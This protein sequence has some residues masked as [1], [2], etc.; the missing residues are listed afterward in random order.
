MS[1]IGRLP[2][3]IFLLSLLTACGGFSAKK[4]M[5]LETPAD[6]LLELK[7]AKGFGVAYYPEY[8]RLEVFNPWK[9]KQVHARYYLTRK[10]S[11][12]LPAD[13]VAIQ[14]PLKTIAIASC[15]HIE[16]LRLLGVLNQVKAVCNASTIYN[17]YLREQIKSHAVA[18]IGDAF[19]INAE[20]VLALQVQAL[21]V[22]GHNQ[23]DERIHF[24]EGTGLPVL[25]NNEWMESDL[26]ARAEWIR[27][28]AVFWG[29]E[30]LADSLF[31][32][33]E[34]NYLHIKALAENADSKAPT[35]LSGDHFRG[36]WYLPAGK[37]F[38]TQLFRDAGG[39]YRLAKDT[40][41][42]SK[43]YSFEQVLR[44]FHDADIWVGAASAASLDELKNIDGRYAWFKAF[45]EKR[46]YSYTRRNTPEGGNDYWES[47]VAHPDSLLAD[48]VKLFHPELLP[49]HEWV[50]LKQLP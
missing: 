13:G 17:A 45:K 11:V 31:R 24:L 26:L 39:D 18:D 22:S 35:I 8:I 7:Y 6:S 2:F 41:S 38:T 50:F 14:I 27:F 4:T 48:F 15:T 47:A 29:K 49:E 1:S 42:G 44:D 23:F 21:A 9:N 19:N 33:T 10:D 36:T 34:K 28:F 25:Y 30:A 16:F 32:E 46:V 40:A 12:K 20:K 5:A 43:P 37:N 3:F